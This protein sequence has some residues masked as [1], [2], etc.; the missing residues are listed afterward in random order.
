VYGHGPGGAHVSVGVGVYYGSPYYYGAYGYYPWY[1]WGGPWYGGPYF[2]YG[3]GY[4]YPYPYY[5]DNSASLQLQVTPRQTEV[6][7]DGHFAGIVDNFDGTFQRLHVEPGEHDLQLFLAGHRAVTQHIYVQPRAT[8]R[9]KH[10]MEALGAGEPEPLRPVAAARAQGPG[11]EQGPGPGPRASGD[12]GPPEGPA[13]Q[14]RGSNAGAV[15][16]RVQ[17]VDAQVLIDGERW[18]GAS[19]GERLVVQLAPGPHTVEVRKDGFRDFMTEVDIRAG[20][21]APLNVSLARPR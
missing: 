19:G 1:P 20:E 17:P 21:T 11:P 8:F 13:P 14:P 2:G 18:D 16:I 5:Y 9:V 12:N 7:I 4:G 6:F 3:Y 15:A 10:A